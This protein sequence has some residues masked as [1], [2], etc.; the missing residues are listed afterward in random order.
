[1][2]HDIPY[3]IAVE[4]G[5]PHQ[6]VIHIAGWVSMFTLHSM[7]PFLWIWATLWRDDRGWGFQHQSASQGGEQPDIAV[8]AQRIAVLEAAIQSTPNAQPAEEQQL[9]SKED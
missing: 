1:M 7:W 9:E 8:L 4:R 5:H 2:I 3:E 6:D